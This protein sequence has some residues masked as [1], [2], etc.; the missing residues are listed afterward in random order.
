MIRIEQAVHTAALALWENVADSESEY[1]R[2]WLFCLHFVSKFCCNCHENGLTNLK[3]CAILTI[4]IK[5]PS[6]WVLRKWMNGRRG[7]WQ[8]KRTGFRQKEINIYTACDR[9]PRHCARRPF[10]TAEKS[11]AVFGI[12]CFPS[13]ME[14]VFLT[15]T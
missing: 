8:S 15:Y 7:L 6:V 1:F 5:L 12:F 14:S 10:E 2:F 11:R 4:A 9:V 3:W 13:V